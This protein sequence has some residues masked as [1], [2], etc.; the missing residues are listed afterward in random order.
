MYNVCDHILLEVHRDALGWSLKIADLQILR[1]SSKTH[2]DKLFLGRDQQDRHLNQS[3]DT[4]A[5]YHA[6]LTKAEMKT[7]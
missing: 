2:L 3:E 1:T 4:T 6:K 5:D 7:E